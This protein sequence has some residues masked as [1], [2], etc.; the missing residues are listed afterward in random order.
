VSEPVWK[1]RS[2]SNLTELED[3]VNTITKAGYTIQ[4]INTT[5]L[6]VVYYKYSKEEE[7]TL[8]LE[9]QDE[10]RIPKTM[11]EDYADGFGASDRDYGQQ[12]F[13]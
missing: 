2:A 1:I 10:G 3:L 5:S 13:E 8:L 6:V 12:L 9:R 7:K 11:D 4:S